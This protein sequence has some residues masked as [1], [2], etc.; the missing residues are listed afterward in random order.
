MPP[1]PNTL[2]ADEMKFFETGELPAS[3]APAPAPVDA[4]APAPSPID[5]AGLSAGTPAPA[6]TPAP[7]PTAEPAAAPAQNDVLASLSQAVSA[8]NQQIAELRA[9]LEA[10]ANPPAPPPP[11]PDKATDPIGAMFHELEQANKAILAL[12]ESLKQQSTQSQQQTALQQFQTNV[13]AMRDEF[14][15]TATDFQDAYNHLRTARV[16]DLQAFGLPQDKINEAIAQEEFAIA[17]TAIQQGKN[18][19]AVVYDMAKRHGY[20]PKQ[21]GAAP[22]PAPGAPTPDDKLRSIQQAQHPNLPRNPQPEEVK[23][24][25]LRNMSD[26]DLNKL[27]MDPASWGKIGGTDHIPI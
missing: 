27:V 20:V 9:Q 24:E 15:K 3:I 11:A 25:S 5:V 14:A 4:P 21:A 19:A 17:Q 6:A 13:R 12:Q 18:P 1:L 7:A 22:A 10:K 23:I 26:A 8:A 16:S 2:T